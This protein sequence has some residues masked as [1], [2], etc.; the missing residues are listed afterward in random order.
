MYTNY[1]STSIYKARARR[2]MRS[3]PFKFIILT[4]AFWA[5]MWLASIIVGLIPFLGMIV[6]YGIINSGITLFDMFLLSFSRSDFGEG[7]IDHSITDA[8]H[9]YLADGIPFALTHLLMDIYVGLWSMLLIFPGIYKYLSYS[10]T[11]FL[12]IDFPHLRYNEAIS[13]SRYLMRGRHWQLIKLKLRFLP[14]YCI[15]MLTLGI[16]YTYQYPYQVLA[17]YYFYCDCLEATQTDFAYGEPFFTRSK[18]QNYHRAYEEALFE[19]G[20]KH[21]SYEDADSWDDF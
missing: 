8:V 12:M 10:F 6:A 15:S 20:P 13:A 14:W 18:H 16:S 4:I 11:D 17:E 21:R 7:N 1:R 2:V 5:A 19:D 9:R 3:D